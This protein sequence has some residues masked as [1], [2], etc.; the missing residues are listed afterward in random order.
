LITIA[1]VTGCTTYQVLPNAGVKM[2]Q[3]ISPATMDSADTIDVS[4]STATGGET[5]SAVHGAFAFDL[6]TCDAVTVTWSTT[7]LT[8]DAAGG[9]TDHTYRVFVIGT[10]KNT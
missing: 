1:A 5:L 10:T 4:S 8:I 2:I 6:T 3:I 7:T 9:T